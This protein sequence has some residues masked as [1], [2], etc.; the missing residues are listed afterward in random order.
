MGRRGPAEGLGQ[1]TYGEVYSDKEL[2]EENVAKAA[3]A[4][5]LSHRSLAGPSG[6]LRE[7]EG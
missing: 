1:L 4:P 7:G 5:L 3:P 2:A 6:E